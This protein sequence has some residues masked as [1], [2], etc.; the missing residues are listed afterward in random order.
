MS[1]DADKQARRLDARMNTAVVDQVDEGVYEVFVPGAIREV[2]TVKAESEDEAK[3]KTR[4][5]LLSKM[6]HAASKKV[7]ATGQ[8][9]GTLDV[10]NGK[11][12]NKSTDI[13]GSEE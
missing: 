2:T 7:D 4:A 8:S 6:E 13:E 9:D 5:L 10:Q 11:H 1:N 12:G 3:E